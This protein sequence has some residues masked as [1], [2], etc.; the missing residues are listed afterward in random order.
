MPT[1]VQGRS[2]QGRAVQG[3][4]A[5]AGTIY[6]VQDFT[7]D[8]LNSS[9]TSNSTLLVPGTVGNWLVIECTAAGGGSPNVTPITPSGGGVAKWIHAAHLVAGDGD[10]SDTWYGQITTAGQTVVVVTCDGAAGQG[11]PGGVGGEF[12]GL[13][14]FPLLIANGGIAQDSAVSGISGPPLTPTAPGQLYV[15]GGYSSGAPAAPYTTEG[16]G[17]TTF[18]PPSTFD[19]GDLAYNL[20]AW[21]VIPYP[22]NAPRQENSV[23]NGATNATVIATPTIKAVLTTSSLILGVQVYLPAALA[24]GTVTDSLGGTWT[25]VY[26]SPLIGNGVQYF[27]YVCNNPA[28]GIHTVTFTCSQ[29]L[30]YGGT[31]FLQEWVDGPYTFDTADVLV[32]G[33]SGEGLTPT[34]TPAGPNELILIQGNSD[35]GSALMSGPTNGFIPF[36]GPGGSQGPTI[37]SAWQIN[38]SGAPISSSWTMTPADS[39]N[40]CII[41]FTQTL[42]TPVAP[43]WATGSASKF[44]SSGII[45]QAGFTQPTEIT[46]VQ[47]ATL[48][49]SATSPDTVLLPGV[50]EHDLLVF[51]F[52]NEG[53]PQPSITSVSDNVGGVWEQGIETELGA[54]SLQDTA[55]WYCLDS[56]GG[57]V[58]ISVAYTE[59]GSYGTLGGGW[60]A[61]YTAYG[62][63]IRFVGGDV[64]TGTSELMQGPS[65]TPEIGNLIIEAGVASLFSYP[66]DIPPAQPPWT[67]DNGPITQYDAGTGD[68]GTNTLPIAWQVANST[69]PQ[70]A[71]WSYVPDANSQSWAS[72][73]MVFAIGIYLV[74]HDESQFASQMP[75]TLNLPEDPIEGDLVVVLVSIDNYQLTTTVVSGPGGNT[76]T[77]V[78]ADWATANEFESEA[79]VWYCFMEGTITDGDI[80]ADTGN[81][82]YAGIS[83]SEW[84]GVGGLDVTGENALQNNF[85][86]AAAVGPLVPTHL[87]D[88]FIHMI[89]CSVLV[90]PGAPW[91]TPDMGSYGGGIAAWQVRVDE[92]PETGYYTLTST[93][94]WAAAAA[95]FY[96]GVFETGTS[97]TVN[98]QRGIVRSTGRKGIVTGGAALAGKRGIVRTTGRHG[99]V[100]GGA[101]VTAKRGITRTTGRHG[102]ATGGALVAAKRGITRTTGRHGTVTGGALVAGQRGTLRTTG[103][104]GTVTFGALI[105]AKRGVLRTAGR[106]A[107][108]TGGALVGAKRG[109]VRTTG[110]AGTAVGGALVTSKRG[111]IRTT[112]RHGTVTGGASVVGKRGI[113]RTTTRIATVTTGASVIGHRGVLRATGR[114][115]TVTG[116]ALV[117]G[118]RVARRIAG[119]AATVSGAAIVSGRRG[120][121]RAT[122][123][124]ATITL[125]AAVVSARGVSRTTS[126]IAT[127]TTGAL[128]VGSRGTVRSAGRAS[129]VTGTVNVVSAR[130]IIRSA[131]RPCGVTASTAVQSV[132]GLVI[133]TG[134][135]ALV[136]AAASIVAARGY[137]HCVGRA[138][139]VT[140]GVLVTAQRRSV[141]FVGR[142]CKVTFSETVQG[143]RGIMRTGGMPA[144]VFVGTI[145][146]SSRTVIRAVGRK[147]AVSGGALVVGRRGTTKTV[148]RAGTVHAGALVIGKRATA[149]L[150]GRA[151]TVVV[152]TT[153]TGK[154]GVVHTAGR[155]CTITFGVTVTARRGICRTTGRHGTAVAGTVVVASRGH[156]LVTGRPSAVT[157]SDLIR[158]SRGYIRAVGAT[159]TVEGTVTL[160]TSSRGLVLFAGR[161]AIVNT[162]SDIPG[163]ATVT[164]F[165]AGAD[166]TLEAASANVRLT[167][168][169]AAVEL[170]TAEINP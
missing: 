24:T 87:G 160:V 29:E 5:T 142:P 19:T 122:G 141:R 101:S 154:R 10:Q 75:I 71:V 135:A 140:T 51:I 161:K 170:D 82:D 85:E 77:W 133:A 108:V 104:H 95:A 162:V 66:G 34:I 35:D 143:A 123:R 15:G 80:T 79:E 103:R 130:G 149:C 38:Q 152:G 168:S 47:S 97:I 2:V 57:D 119:R 159:C 65:V 117:V 167:S 59:A 99:T 44:V 109:I 116:G 157:F 30:Q 92:S 48:N 127:V 17:W 136:S 11:Y 40:S 31:A 67:T 21:Q 37:S 50:V 9:D 22:N 124:P 134:R 145:V 147:A 131:A 164:L 12:G 163:M 156:L 42:P 14:N 41:A 28:A 153:V 58:T 3:L 118:S 70:Q 144:M 13:G 76:G 62:Q 113:L 53:N 90:G 46:F 60:A 165:A 106:P 93:T 36:L 114:V 166:V 18:Q 61:E 27:Y 137:T 146:T 132:R 69:A 64:L 16:P 89:S 105:P 63:A 96:P 139:A 126:R 148:G 4:G 128:V 83:V 74:Q 43:V 94:N 88:L 78:R 8:P 33:N 73:S 155:V 98:G 129:A 56:P 81:S 23:Y 84:G 55:G 1:G 25:P 91:F 86:N 72:I 20:A 150:V 121:L 39:G 102:T 68:L 107:T 125:G 7:P 32:F 115:S 45:L 110:R 138:A 169:N 54:Y 6:H 26:T 158:G 52:N 120:V 111:I 112:G 100:T 151:A 49:N